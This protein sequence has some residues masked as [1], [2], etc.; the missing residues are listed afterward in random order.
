MDLI[1]GDCNVVSLYVFCFPVNGSVCFVCCVFVNCLVKQFAIC[2]GV[3]VILLLH[4]M[5]LL[6]VVG[7]ALWIDHVRSSIEGVCCACGPSECLDAPSK[8]FVCV[9]YVGSYLLI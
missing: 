3:F 9:L 7:G 1:R 6:S 4:M 2:F 5:E 8:C